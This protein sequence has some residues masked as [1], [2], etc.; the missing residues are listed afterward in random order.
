MIFYLPFFLKRYNSL[1]KIQSLGAKFVGIIR[2]NDRE[3]TYHARTSL[4]SRNPCLKINRRLEL[5]VL[6][7]K[8]Q[9]VDVESFIMNESDWIDRKYKEL[10]EGKKAIENNRVLYRGNYYEIFIVDSPKRDYGT[11]E[12]LNGKAIV[13]GGVGS[14]SHDLL[15]NWMKKETANYVM[16]KVNALLTKY[17]IKPN[18]IFVRSITKWGLCTRKGDLSF[19]WQLIALPEELSEYVVMHELA[20]LLEFNHSKRFKK[21]LS[22]MCP[23]YSERQRML[24]KFFT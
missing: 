19:N 24:M 18:G 4:R 7:P 10:S 22:K 11:V 20:H 17:G 8:G 5:E 6:I 2:I 14:D 16:Q 13:Y 3:F 21:A 15:A 1:I 23:D 9:T 12:I